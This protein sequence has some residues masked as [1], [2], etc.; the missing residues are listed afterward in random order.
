MRAVLP[1]LERPEHRLRV[2]GNLARLAGALSD[3]DDFERSW[4]EVAESLRIHA[5]DPAWDDAL[6]DALK[7]AAQGA[8]SIGDPARAKWAVQR[9]EPLAERARR[10]RDRVQL[11][12]ILSAAEAALAGEEARVERPQPDHPHPLD[13]SLRVAERCVGVLAGRTVPA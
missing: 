7:E 11:D 13:V 9:A 4:G 10:G 5:G 3:R 8:V 2:V 12:S 6:T 1:H